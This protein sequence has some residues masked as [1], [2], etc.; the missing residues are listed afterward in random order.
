MFSFDG[1]V[2]V[3]TGGA[4]GIGA[5]TAAAFAR[6]GASVVIADIDRSLADEVAAEIRSNGA[7]AL[8]ITTDVRVE[9]QIK[10]MV[11]DTIREFGRLDVLHNNAAALELTAVEQDVTAT[12][13]DVWE[14][15][16]RTNALGPML[17][18]KHAIPAMLETGGGSIVMTSSAS[19]T[20]GE[21]MLTSYSASKA[22]VSQLTRAVATQWARRGVRCNAV[23]P[24][25]V[26]TPQTRA[27]IPSPLLSAYEKVTSTPD[28][29]APEDIAAAVL[30]LASDEARYING[31]V[32]AVD[33]G[34]TA[35]NPI[36]GEL[37]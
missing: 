15:T 31:A 4:S 8:A 7:R 6:Q 29:G 28:V 18:C 27:H 35:D 32:L 24:G 19:A 13:V 2:A 3:I 12:E 26:L 21:L 36:N 37:R 23:A 22:A 11:R 1:K 34:L 17:G 33:G 14:A 10:N 9:S 25:L 5:A 16:F 20:Q 30:F